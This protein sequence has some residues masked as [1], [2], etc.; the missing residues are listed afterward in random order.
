MFLFILRAKWRV[1]FREERLVCMIGTEA[2][3][4][5]S[6]LVAAQTIKKMIILLGFILADISCLTGP[7]LVKMNVCG[8]LM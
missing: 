8:N 5:R 4:G 3:G 2:G 7:K 1:E 6:C